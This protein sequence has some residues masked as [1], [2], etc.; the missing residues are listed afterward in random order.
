[1]ADW[2]RI[3]T[4]TKLIEIY[5]R[6]IDNPFDLFNLL[7]KVEFAKSGWEG[8]GK[9]FKE[10][11]IIEAEQ[12][13]TSNCAKNLEEEFMFS[14]DM[15]M[16]SIMDEDKESINKKIANAVTKNKNCGFNL[17]Y[18][19]ADYKELLP[20]MWETYKFLLNEKNM[21]PKDEIYQLLLNDLFGT[22][23]TV[24]NSLYDSEIAYA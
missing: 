20:V 12:N 14:M 4:N 5:S 21:N 22:E 24:R 9:V 3:K 2:N 11:P 10:N 13:Y 1:M 19:L 8:A 18:T 16:Y 6:N 17:I 23:T 15:W 7:K